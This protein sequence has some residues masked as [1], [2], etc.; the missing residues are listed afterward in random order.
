MAW[1]QFSKTRHIC[2]KRLKSTDL[3]CYTNVKST[4]TGDSLNGEKCFESKE[5]VMK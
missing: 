1:G 3:S 5:V 2:F 4:K